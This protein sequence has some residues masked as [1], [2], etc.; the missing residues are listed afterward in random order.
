MPAASDDAK[1]FVLVIVVTALALWGCAKRDVVSDADKVYLHKVQA[2]ETFEQIADEYYGDP[3]RARNI[4]AFNGLQDADLRPDLIVRVP[5]GQDDIRWLEKREKARAPYNEGL[6]LAGEASYLDA[7][8][9]F[10]AALEID[11]DFVDARYNL[12][13]TFQKMKAYERAL[14][15][16]DEAVRQR[17]S[18]PAYHFARGTCLFHLKRYDESALA[19]ERVMELD[20]E[21]A[22]ALFSLAASYER[23]GETEKARKAWRRYLELDDSSVWATEARKRLAALE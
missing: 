13:V 22:K 7:V 3:E 15:E 17:P 8:K 2:G 11:P 5:V 6:E 4:A 23:L 9:K 21:H 16:L 18:R 14:R 19:L 20:P 1:R 12:G 10:Q